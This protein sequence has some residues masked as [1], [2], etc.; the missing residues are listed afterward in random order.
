MVALAGIS[1]ARPLGWGN[2]PSLVPIDGTAEVWF[3]ARERVERLVPAATL[4]FEAAG[5][6][7]SCKV[8]GSFTQVQHFDPAGGWSTVLGDHPYFS[9]GEVIACCARAEGFFAAGLHRSAVR[10]RRGALVRTYL[11]THKPV[12]FGGLASTVAGGVIGGYLLF[13]LGWS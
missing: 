8:P 10:A 2:H 9:L 7:I 12:L 4:A 3:A 6:R 5:I 1:D 13:R 11:L